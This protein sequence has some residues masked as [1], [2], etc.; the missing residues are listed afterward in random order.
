MIDAAKNR[1]NEML[2]LGEQEIYVF[3]RL[4]MGS[5]KLLIP[6]SKTGT[7][8]NFNTLTKLLDIAHKL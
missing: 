6:A 3:Y 7:A 1:D 4:G 5:S 8:R 2:A